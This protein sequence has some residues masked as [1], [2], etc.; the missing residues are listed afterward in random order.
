MESIIEILFEII[1]VPL[2]KWDKLKIGYKVVVSV[3]VLAIVVM[4]I[5]ILIQKN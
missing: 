5:Y 4:G 3:V 1:S 2:Q